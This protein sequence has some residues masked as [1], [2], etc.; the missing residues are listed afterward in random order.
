MLVCG[1]EAVL[2]VEVAFHTHRITTFQDHDLR[3]QLDLLP[4]VRGDSYLEEAI[5]KIRITRFYNH[6]VKER[7]LR[8]E[9][10]VLRNGGHRKGSNPME[11]HTI[12]EVH[13]G[14]F[15]LSTVQIER[16]P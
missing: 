14:T 6:K 5:A 15:R 13:P 7:P 16:I 12:E 1:S 3:E 8:E 2:R 4:M 9:G 11:A 10:L